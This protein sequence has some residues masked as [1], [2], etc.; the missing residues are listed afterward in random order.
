MRIN[1]LDKADKLFE[2]VPVKPMLTG[3]DNNRTEHR[4]QLGISN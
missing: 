3:K 1:S 4:Q 2:N